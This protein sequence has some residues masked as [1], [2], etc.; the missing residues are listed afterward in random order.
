MYNDYTDLTEKEKDELNKFKTLFF[1]GFQIRKKCLLLGWVT[2][3][4]K[5]SKDSKCIEWISEKINN[6]QNLINKRFFYIGD[7][8]NIYKGENENSSVL[9]TKITFMYQIISIIIFSKKKIF[10]ILMTFFYLIFFIKV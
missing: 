3:T 5:L 6:N 1:E 8:K 4:I 10:M 2:R 9:T 7:I